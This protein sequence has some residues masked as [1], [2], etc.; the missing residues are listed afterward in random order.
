MNEEGRRERG[1]WS[2]RE[3]EKCRK[4]SFCV[5]MPALC[6]VQNESLTKPFDT[7]MQGEPGRLVFTP[8]P[9]ASL[10]TTAR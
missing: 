6:S 7:I 5:N 2:R 3:E 9:L 8:R 4:P 1:G 10:V